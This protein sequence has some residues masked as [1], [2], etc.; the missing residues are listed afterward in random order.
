MKYNNKWLT[1]KFQAK[2]KIKFLFF[3]GH[4]VSKDGSITQSCFSQW[5]FANFEVNGQ[6]YKTAEHWMMAE[7][8]RLF[9]DLEILE[10]IFKAKNPAEAKKLGRLIRGFDARIWDENKFQIVVQGNYHKFS[11][12]KNLKDFLLNTQDRILVE[13]SPV[14]SIWGIGMAQDNSNIEN[15]LLWKGQNLLGYALMEVR[16]SLK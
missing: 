15:P 6:I 16:D 13:A 1:G 3:W 5:W 10:R 9:N 14:D 12:H 4:Q 11:Q 8:A 2:K 7:K